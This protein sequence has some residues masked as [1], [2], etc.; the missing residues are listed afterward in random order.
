MSIFGCF[1]AVY[2]HNFHFITA[3]DLK[4]FHLATTCLPPVQC[5]SR[6]KTETNQQI[7]L[8]FCGLRIKVNKVCVN[9]HNK[10]RPAQKAAAR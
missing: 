9:N 6:G 4:L 1:W 10:T 8:M 5:I 7:S 2:T 3:Y